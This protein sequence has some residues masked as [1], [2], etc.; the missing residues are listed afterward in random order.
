MI[1][2]TILDCYYLSVT[3]PV[4]IAYLF[5]AFALRVDKFTRAALFCFC[6]DFFQFLL[7]SC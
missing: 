1:K 4:I 3:L 7:D 2:T 6:F 5:V